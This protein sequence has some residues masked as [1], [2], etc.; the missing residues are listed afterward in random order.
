MS[1]RDRSVKRERALAI[2]LLFIFAA[3]LVRLVQIQ[4]LEHARWAGIA[5]R[6]SELMVSQK[7]SRGEIRDRNGIPLA[8]TLP[9]TYA[10]GY[11]PKLG[12]DPERL[13]AQLSVCLPIS[14]VSLR[15]KLQSDG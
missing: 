1:E 13:A 2:V 3:F 14:K 10:V 7:P 4:V 15:S 12:L 8:V 6:Q 9:L 11:H 5:R